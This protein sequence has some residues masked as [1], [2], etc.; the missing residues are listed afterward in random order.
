MSAYPPQPVTQKKISRKSNAR[1]AVSGR[2]KAMIATAINAACQTF[3]DR[4]LYRSEKC[5][6][7]P[8]S[9]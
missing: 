7:S 2:T 4:V 6:Q 5:L 8:F 9:P 3:I 1:F